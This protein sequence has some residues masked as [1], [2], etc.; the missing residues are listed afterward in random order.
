MLWR[1]LVSGGGA[2]AARTYGRG[3]W[4]SGGDTAA[5]TAAGTARPQVRPSSVLWATLYG[6]WV[7]CWG[8]CA[9]CLGSMA[10]ATMAG[11]W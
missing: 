6:A 5:G 2:S 11:C 7:A 1:L 4:G 8:G 10:G 9:C 3:T